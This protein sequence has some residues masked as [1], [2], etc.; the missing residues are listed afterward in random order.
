MI[1]AV[2]FDFYGVFVTDQDKLLISDIVEY[3]PNAARAM[4]DA[5]K[6]YNLGMQS[7]E[8]VVNVFSEST[9]KTE[10]EIREQFKKDM[11]LD[12]KLVDY[13][14]SI[15][16]KG[17]KTALLSNT[18]GESIRHYLDEQN[19]ESLFDQMVLSFEVGMIKPNIGIYLLAA[20]R[21]GIEPNEAMFIDDRSYNCDGAV[22]A[23]MQALLYTDFSQ[24]KE[25]LE[26][27]LGN[28]P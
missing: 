28:H 23:G 24:I 22:L 27:F 12:K 5:M 10:E 19:L 13:V 25:A 16:S 6:A 20:E 2:I 26:P 1:K 21:L 11:A 14:R 18:G 15:R 8:Y 3:N 9:H 17:I 4:S 7:F